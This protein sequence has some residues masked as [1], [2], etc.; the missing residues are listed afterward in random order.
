[1][2]VMDVCGCGC[3]CEDDDE[4]RRCLEEEEKKKKYFNQA[5]RDADSA[6]NVRLFFLQ[7]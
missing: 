7:Q 5:S 4:G 3:R 6:F 1:M 2:D